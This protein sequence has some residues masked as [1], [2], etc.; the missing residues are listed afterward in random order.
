MGTI[1]DAIAESN[2][3]TNDLAAIANAYPDALELDG[4]FRSASA[5]QDCD[6]IELYG[7]WPMVTFRRYVVVGSTRVYGRS[8][9]EVLPLA[10]D[11]LAAFLAADPDAYAALLALI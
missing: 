11:V 8:E 9:G 3:S 6:R 1:A 2:K 7:S 5:K 10:E 4:E